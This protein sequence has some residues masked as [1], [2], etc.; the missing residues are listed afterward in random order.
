MFKSILQLIWNL[1]AIFGLICMITFFCMGIFVLKSYE[2]PVPV[3]GQKILNKI[4]LGSSAIAQKLTPSSTR[5]DD[6]ILPDPGSPGWKGIGARND[7]IS[8]PVLY[9]RD[10]RPFPKGWL[11]KT[12]MGSYS[13]QNFNRTILVKESKEMISAIKNAE[14]GD[15]IKLAPGVYTINAYNIEIIK[16]GNVLMPI[17]IKAE[18]LGQVVI[19]MNS[20]EGFFMAAPYWI[21]EN[22][23]FKGINPSHDEGEHAFHITGKAKGF[24]LRNCRIHEFNAMIKAN[25]VKDNSGKAFFPDD[26][27]IENNSFYNSMIR[28]TSNPVTFIDVVG[29]N[30][31]IIRGNFIADF[32]KGEGD[33]ISYAAFVK[34]NASGTIFES[35]LVIGEYRHTGGIRVGL[36]LGGGGT[37]KQFFRD[38]ITET[39]HKNGI[40]R[41]NVIMYCKDAGIY[42]NKST[43][44]KILHNL[45]Y[46]T[47]GIDVRYPQSSAQIENN[48][49]T[50]RVSNRDGGTSLLNN[51]II[52][53]KGFFKS[54]DFSESYINPDLADFS[55]K[56][57]KIIIEKGIPSDNLFEDICGN[58][59]NSAPDIGP[60]EYINL[61]ACPLIGVN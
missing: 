42:L 40:I 14:P 38:G 34:G 58:S 15:M 39:E 19:E 53:E 51:N 60:F 8:E 32:S 33:T 30:R 18:S 10:G 54:H 47:M 2:Y 48:I 36:S 49:L 11:G 59:R 20:H 61:K 29:A 37:G 9:D 26:A 5:P 21:F 25:G 28:K 17:C 16:P 23:E 12:D 52:L 24:V 13:I 57:N 45:L 43:D 4:G 44:T 22:I 46:K 50:S 7:R 55:L 41:N 27:L 1:L 56:T 3:I 6:L 31:W 35:N